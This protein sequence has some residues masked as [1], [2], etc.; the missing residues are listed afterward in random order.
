MMLYFDNAAQKFAAI[1]GMM[2]MLLG[3]AKC[4]GSIGEHVGELL[5]WK[6]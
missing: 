2:K 5:A 3:I 6:N 4:T 1:H